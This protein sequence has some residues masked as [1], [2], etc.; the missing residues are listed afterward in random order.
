M[1][2]LKKVLL[3]VGFLWLSAFNLAHSQKTYGISGKVVD[4]QG[5]TMPGV[6]VLIKGT[7]IGTSTDING[8]FS[9]AAPS[10]EVKLVFSFIGTVP[11]EIT[12][13]AGTPVRVVMESKSVGLSELVVVGYGVQ[14]KSVV[15]GAIS[16]VKAKD[17]ENNQILRV[18]QALQGRTSGLTIASSSGQPGAGIT[19]RVRGT[20]SIN[21]SDPL[22]VVDGVPVDVGG[23]DY[24]N[25]SDVESIEVLKDAASAAIYG[26][27][28]ANGVILITTKKGKSG[29]MK[30]SYN[31]YFGTQSPAK[32][33]DLLNA[34]EYATLQNEAQQN[35]NIQFNKNDK[36]PFP[37]LETNPNYFGAGTDW[38]G[39]IF[40]NNAKIQNHELSISGGNNIST[41]YTSFGYTDQE[42]IVASSISNYKR[43]NI[44]MNS[45]HKVKSWLRLGENVG[46][47]HIKSKGS[48]NTNSEFGGPLSSAINLD[49]TTPTVITNDSI[50]GLDLYSKHPVMRD[51]NGN[52][53]GI[54]TTVVQEMSNPLAYIKAHQGNYGWSDNIVG[55]VFAEVEPIKGL[56]FKSDL[57][58]KLAFW[59]DESFTP[60]VWYNAY[61]PPSPKNS[62]YRSNSKGMT[63]NFEN[64]VSYTKSIGLH[65]ATILLGTSA[66]VDNSSGVSS[67]FQNL[68]VNTFEE[69]SVKYSFVDAD[70]IG[71][72]WENAPHKIS[73]LFARLTYNYNEKYLFTGIV[74]R[75]GSTRFGS[76]NKYGVF[77]SASL[78]WVASREGFWP[79]NKV[80]D[81]LKIRGSYGVT[82][83][84]NIPD[85]LYF[86]TVSGGRNY[87]FGYDNYLIGYS[88]DA[89]AN[90]DLHWEE[91][92]QSNIGFEMNLFQNFS[93]VFDLYSKKTTGMLRPFV[94][95]AY[96]GSGSPWGNVASMTNKG[97]E[98]E[99]GYRAEVGKVNI[100]LKGNASYLKNEITDL[101]SVKYLDA[102]NLQSMGVISRLAVG[103][104]IGSFY[105]YEAMGVFAKQ[106]DILSYKDPA[107]G[108]VIQPNA[109]P[110]DLQ[111]RDLNGRDSLGNLTGKPD[112]KIDVDDKTYIGDPT[113]TWSFGF[114]FSANYSGFDV[115]IF[116]QGVVGNDVFNGLRRLEISSANWTSDAMN[117]W[118][119]N[120]RNTDFPRIILGDPN[121]NFTSS[122]TFYLTNGSYFRVKTIQIGYTLP[123]S[124][125][126][127]IGVDKLRVYVSTNNLLTITKY[128][129]YDPE[130]GGSSYSIDRGVYP[131]AKS[132]LAGL[133]LTF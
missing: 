21:N 62:L 113:P 27:R 71:G 75:D 29:S 45:V 126:S 54:S 106:S 81:F 16:S 107:T 105:G 61:S 119:P 72:G 8:G 52:P 28:A 110:G 84:D 11:Q 34:T 10:Q 89:P 15:T 1:K 37:Q 125:M 87:T 59:G 66:Y 122:S 40:N 114:T 95:P 83:N 25:S 76:N 60:I 14:K 120:N 47:S 127:K 104:P 31:T 118:T 58:A 73:S 4:N 56:V 117:R 30:V 41:F 93:L 109:Q 57:G 111:F 64:T 116:G 123:A 51:E 53:Y 44:R 3:I 91:T 128:K 49:P 55:D 13:I 26:T 99:L 108:K 112:G 6:T 85:F 12:A 67:T 23:I 129:G 20:T 43:L 86:S 48:L 17:L 100:D 94:L 2:S 97:F 132:F 98:I 131:Q 36:L 78:G 102:A 65:N 101:G 70:K 90:P 19:V 130:I 63:W 69:A 50:A 33:L 7:S 77:P 5:E 103:H 80:V 88:P 24:L 82:G 68:P 133:S 79:E 92:S 121:K 32:K 115:M 74:R 18:E 35:A 46:Y 39:T 96:T 124:L 22:Y 9:L 38:Q 42:G